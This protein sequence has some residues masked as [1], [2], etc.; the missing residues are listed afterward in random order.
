V[1]ASGEDDNHMLSHPLGIESIGVGVGRCKSDRPAQTA[2]S[3]MLA[4][5]ERQSALST[6]GRANEPIIASSTHVSDQFGSVHSEVITAT[7]SE[8]SHVL[9]GAL[10]QQTGQ[11]IVEHMPISAEQCCYFLSREC[12]RCCITHLRQVSQ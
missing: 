5:T 11:Q 6:P 1:A 4:G 2:S 8:A 7:A 12:A 3:R 9:D 10:Y